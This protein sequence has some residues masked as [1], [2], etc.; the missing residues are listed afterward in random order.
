MCN[1]N[2]LIG[3]GGTIAD[4]FRANGTSVSRVFAKYDKNLGQKEPSVEW[5]VLGGKVYGQPFI[6]EVGA[7]AAG[8]DISNADGSNWQSTGD[9][10]SSWI[11]DAVKSGTSIAN[12]VI[13]GKAQANGQAPVII[14]TPQGPQYAPQQYGQPA[15]YQQYPQQSTAPT[16]GFTNTQIFLLVATAAVIAALF[17]FSRTSQK[18]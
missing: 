10:I 18:A 5:A 6:N 12:T 9:T 11:S 3:N 13:A 16:S 1:C 8:G 7:A 14:Q 2:N 17:F 15:Y 4:F